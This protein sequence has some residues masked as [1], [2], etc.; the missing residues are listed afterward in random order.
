MVV[1]ARGVTVSGIPVATGVIVTILAFI[2]AAF[3]RVVI[4]KYEKPGVVATK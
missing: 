4:P 3:T 1:G 2:V